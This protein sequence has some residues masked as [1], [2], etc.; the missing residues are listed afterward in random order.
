MTFDST[1]LIGPQPLHA[2]TLRDSIVMNGFAVDL[3]E[4]G[5][6]KTY[7]AAAIARDLSSHP[8]VLIAPKT[9]LRTWVQI[10]N[11]FG[12]QPKLAIN[13][14]LIGRGNTKWM[15]FTKQADPC[16]P[17]VPGATEKLPHFR[18]PKDAF[19]ILDEGHR[20]KGQDTTNSQMLISLVV[21]KYKVLVSSATAAVSPLDMK[22]LGYLLQLH[23]LHDFP[24]FCRLHGAQWVGKWGAM[25]FSPDDPAAVKG[26]KGLHN[27]IF[28]VRKCASR[29]VREQFGDL[30]PESHVMPEA[31]DL[32][33]N[34]RKI[35][36]V[37]EDMEYELAKLEEHC[38]NYRE[39]VFAILTKAR[40]QA[41]MLKV[42]TFVDMI[43][44][45]YD[46]GKSVVLFANFQD[47]I[48]A[49]SDRLN[50]KKKFA[51]RI[52]YVV[53]GQTPK[54]REQMIAAFQNNV[55]K[56]MLTNISAGGVAISLH[57]LNGDHPRASIVSPNWSAVQMVQAL[58]R[59]WRA[60]GKSK[61][62]QR[63]VYAAGC[64]EEQICRRVQDKLTM[65][66]ML[67]DGDLFEATEW[68]GS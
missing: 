20:C 41:E 9:V 23:N 45:L 8:L 59:V 19:V 60:G 24:D 16:R 54:T 12:V 13:Y 50:R 26:M 48:D 53:G 68:I 49:V 61:S 39:H 55:K 14:E 17:H 11:G 36:K 6:G 52:G 15:R 28:H 21:Q 7:A 57:D 63:I 38:A 10:L 33:S 35:Q 18:F 2:Q 43:E 22:A 34:E 64:I 44:D 58:G 1:G 62:L 31:Y 66:S 5:C 25:T 4:T 67:N 56:V 40:R 65:L 30:F 3:S 42:P 37:Y 27:Y 32:G 46:E 51:G 47:T 29:M